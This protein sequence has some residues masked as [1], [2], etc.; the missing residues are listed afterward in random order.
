MLGRPDGRRPARGAGAGC[1]GEVLAVCGLYA[2]WLVLIFVTHARLPPA[3]LYANP[4]GPAGGVSQILTF[5]GHPLSVAAVAVALVLVG[6]LGVRTGWSLWRRAGAASFA[7]GPWAAVSDWM[8]LEV[9]SVHA[10]GVPVVVLT[11]ALTV[12]AVRAHGVGRLAPPTGGD[13]VRLLL[14][15]G[16]LVLALP[17]LCADLGIGTDGPPLLGSVYA[18]V[19]L[20][21]HHGMDGTLLAL[22]ALALSRALGP[23]HPSRLRG[24]A[25]FYLAF[26]L[27]YGLWRVGQ[28]FWGEQ[29]VGRGWASFHLPQA[30][31]EGRPARPALW[32]ALLLAAGLVHARWFRCATGSAAR[33]A[34][35]RPPSGRAALRLGPRRGQGPADST[36]TPPSPAGHRSAVYP[37]FPVARRLAFGPAGS[38]PFT[39]RYPPVHR[40]SP[41]RSPSAG[42][43]GGNARPRAP[44]GAV[45]DRRTRDEV[46]GGVR[47]IGSRWRS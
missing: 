35:S 31:G 47:C 32:A 18:P 3:R 21:H 6:R 5:L 9:Q 1:P 46:E 7:V 42:R 27:A 23:M 8:D 4:G 45:V 24:A 28:D 40:R 11:L 43:V 20:G 10:L 33:P 15:G 41:A 2:S 37:R 39:A 36:P 22:T 25:S 26:L 44:A 17:W 38:P 30:V 13:R 12:G 16:L 14:G 19:H 34:A 29:V